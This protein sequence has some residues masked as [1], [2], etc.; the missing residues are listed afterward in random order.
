MATP[1]K[2][3]IPNVLCHDQRQVCHVDVW[4]WF[5]RASIHGGSVVSSL[6]HVTPQHALL[7]N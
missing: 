7:D 2:H 6:Q 3:I 4:A 5:C 1:F